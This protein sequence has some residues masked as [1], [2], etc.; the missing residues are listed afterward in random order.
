MRAG[1]D[2]ADL[3]ANS[4]KQKKKKVVD[5]KAS[6]GRKLRYVTSALLHADAYAVS[7]RYEPHEKLQHFMVPVHVR[8]AWH[9]EQVDELFASLLGKGFEGKGVVG[10]EDGVAEDPGRLEKESQALQGFR[11]FG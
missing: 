7:G 9:E 1:I 4:K 3:H 10:E 5:T 8:G 11:V 6:K 2:A